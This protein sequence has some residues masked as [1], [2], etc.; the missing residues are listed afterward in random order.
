MRAYVEKMDIFIRNKSYNPNTLF[1]ANCNRGYTN[2]RAPPKPTWPLHPHSML[3][4]MAAMTA[5]APPDHLYF[6]HN[7]GTTP[8]TILIPLS[9]NHPTITLGLPLLC[10][11]GYPIPSHICLIQTQAA[12]LHITC[13]PLSLEGM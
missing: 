11:I 13:S 7:I 10:S 9:S 3:K 12:P 2:Q 5:V 8:V 4:S 1:F 6:R